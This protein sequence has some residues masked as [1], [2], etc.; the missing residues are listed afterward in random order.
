MRVVISACLTLASAALVVII[1]YKSY[2]GIESLMC[3]VTDGGAMVNVNKG[4]IVQDQQGGYMTGGSI[5]LRGARPKTLQPLV[6]Q[7]PKFSFDACSGSA[8]FRF[9]SLSFL[10]SPEYSRF[11]KSIGTSLRGIFASKLYMKTIGPVIENILSDL[12]SRAEFINGLMLEQCSAAQTI[13][14]GAISMINAGSRQKCMMQ[15]NLPGNVRSD[16]Y[17]ATERCKNNPDTY[18][19]SGEDNELKSLLGNEFNLVWKAIKGDNGA[20]DR[21]FKE[22]IMSVSGTII[23]R[24]DGD[25]YIFTG[26]PSLLMSQELLE[27][28]IGIDESKNS[29]NL[30]RCDETDKCLKP[31]EVEHVL[32]PSQ[33]FYGKTKTIIDSLVGKISAKTDNGV[34][35][36]SVE[37]RSTLLTPQ[38]ENL[39]AF[40]SIPIISLIETELISKAGSANIMVRAPEFIEV[41][42]YD[43]ITNYLSSMVNIARMSVSALEQAQIDGSVMGRFEADSK[44]VLG[45]LRD[46]R[47]GAFKRL[48]ITMQVKERLEQQERLFEEGF[49]RFMNQNRQP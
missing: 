2:A 25:H 35:G 20:L 30:Y 18:G 7:M 45:F 48:Q 8:D 5:L 4:T 13:A 28:F 19:V 14:D 9:G 17:D 40:S 26:K 21:E 10:S 38:E 24:K 42:C 3:Y 43:V 6:V 31:T 47:S 16:M 12:S 32:T 36:S 23:G 41:I 33:T 15:S 49:N 11:F 34:D 39:I 27:R 37:S 44:V 46:S 1:P 29:I 22:L